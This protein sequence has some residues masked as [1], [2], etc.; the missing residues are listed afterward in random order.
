MWSEARADLLPVVR[1][2]PVIMVHRNTSIYIKRNEVIASLGTNV[3]VY[4]G[5]IYLTYSQ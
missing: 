4:A 2:G 1:L 3:E 5:Y